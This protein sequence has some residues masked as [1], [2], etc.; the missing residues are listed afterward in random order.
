ML[1]QALENTLPQEY[2][3]AE[4]YQL[5]DQAAELAAQGADISTLMPLLHHHL[6]MCHDCREEYEALLNVLQAG[7]A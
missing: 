2:S 5:L 3:C 4:V 6:E 1:A 7:M